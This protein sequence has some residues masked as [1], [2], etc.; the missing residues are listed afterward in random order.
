MKIKEIFYSIQ[1]EGRN[2]GRPAVFCRFVGCNLW[3]GREQDR[4][5]AICKFCDTDFLGGDDYTEDELVEKIVG[6][7][8]NVGDLV[9]FAKGIAAGGRPLVVFT[10]GE[11]GL[12]ITTT[13]LTALRKRGFDVAIETNGTVALPIGP[14]YHITVSPKAGTVIRQTFGHELKVVWPQNGIDLGAMEKLDFRNFY[15]Q[16]MDGRPGSIQETLEMVLR[17]PMWKL[18]LQ[19]H[20][21][22]GVR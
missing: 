9:D 18:S 5:S 21:I 8:G 20:K 19:T 6:T 1:G 10:G 12:Q 13:I 15:L 16:P 7:W 17:N 2:A 11:P 14:V 22:I 3:S 4:A